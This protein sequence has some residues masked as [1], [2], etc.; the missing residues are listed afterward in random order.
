MLTWLATN[1]ETIITLVNSIGVV[2]L[3]M[4]SKGS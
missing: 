1:W 4:R 2:L 3:H